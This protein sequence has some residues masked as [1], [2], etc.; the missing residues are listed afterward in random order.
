MNLIEQAK[1]LGFLAVG[2]SRPHTPLFYEPFR[3]WIAAGKHGDMSWMANHQELR[4]NPAGLHKGCRTIISL[5]FPYSPEKP[6]TSDGFSVS[7]YADPRETDY[8]DRLR[9]KGK[10]LAGVIGQE[11]PGARSRVCVDS[12]PLLER[13]FACGSGIGF[14]GK[15]NMLIIPGHG[16]Y[17]FLMEILT[18]ALI[19]FPD[20][21]SVKSLCGECTRCL[22]ACPTGA[23]EAPYRVNASKCLS[24]LTI[25]KKDGIH[26]E[27]G[28]KMGRCFFG[29]DICQEACPHNRGKESAVVTLPAKDAILNMQ[30]EDFDEAFGK[31][32]L[33]RAGLEKIKGNIAALI[34]DHGN[35]TKSATDPHGQTRTRAEKME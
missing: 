5:A 6:L 33:A 20:V 25:E 17:L 27:T 22:D 34:G 16:S 2:F 15:N 12:A 7:R 29:C 26:R 10:I 21:E 14:I 18:T 23:L 31:T 11:Y 3:A 1:D 30:A 32:A 35:H 24:Y 28:R 8:H 13:S 19:C 9:K 4:E